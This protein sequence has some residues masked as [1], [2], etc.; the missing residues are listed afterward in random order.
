VPPSH[1]GQPES[2]PDGRSEL[3]QLPD[4]LVKAIESFAS[5]AETRRIENI[6]Q[7]YETL[8][9]SANGMGVQD[10][11]PL[12][13]KAIGKSALS[14]IVSAYA[15]EKCF[16]CQSGSIP[17]EACGD[18]DTDT[19]SR[20]EH[21]SSTGLAPCEFCAGTGWVGND[22]IPHELRRAVWKYRLKHTHKLLEKYARLYDRVF[23]DALSRRPLDDPQRRRAIVETLRLSAKLRSLTE[24]CA[25]T[26]PKH[27]KHLLA[28]EQKVRICLTMLS[29]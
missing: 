29:W 24:S 18:D 3:D 6:C 1:N 23:L 15:H 5:A 28:A 9:S 12:V 8:K 7:A 10:L 4:P 17:C 13:D 2:A 20:C 19:R 26:D 14:L 21:C 16:M 27:A 11:L 22:V 25:V